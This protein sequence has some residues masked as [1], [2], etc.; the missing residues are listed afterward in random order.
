VRSTGGL[1]RR[2][3]VARSLEASGPVVAVDAGDSLVHAADLPAEG[4]PGAEA[5]ARLVLSAM[6]RGGVAG[7]AVGERD[8]ALGTE[9]LVRE[10]R[11]A[12]V[13]LLAANLRSP[14][15]ARPFAAHRLVDGPGE[16]VGIFAVVGRGVGSAEIT[17]TDPADAARE[18]AAALRAKGATLV[19]ALLHMGY[20]E[21][22]ELARGGLQVD[23]AICAHDGKRRQ[24]EPIG[25]VLLA[26]PS[27]RGRDVLAIT[28]RSGSRGPW[29]DVGAPARAEE[30]R[31]SIARWLAIARERLARA[32]A[33]ADRQAI[34]DFIAIQEERAA[35]AGRRARARPEGRLFEPRT[36][37][38]DA[39]VPED[40]ALLAEVER[41]TAAYG[42]PPGQ[43]E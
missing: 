41:V 27:D 5:R 20:E 42:P 34:E 10:A 40:A 32:T 4:R 15:G 22:V 26:A 24:P 30:E 3:G 2:V 39:D 9:W 29:A 21:A 23:V 13:P 19:V 25:G 38:L 12:G 35:D 16:R 8:L 31:R 18:A 17:V 33:A 14:D 37:P 28:L 43:E 1:A 36:L 6:A 11:A 7:V